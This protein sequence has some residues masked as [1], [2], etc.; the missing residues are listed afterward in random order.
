MALHPNFP[1][2]PYTILDPAIRWFPA[3]EVL[4]ETSADKLM[5][6]LVPQL[7]KRVKEW[8]DR[9]QSQSAHLVV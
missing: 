2:S 1:E 8:R 3:G 5:P 9:H 4:R 6:P 7:R